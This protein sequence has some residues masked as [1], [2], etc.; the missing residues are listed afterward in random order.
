MHT[1]IRIELPIPFP[2]G[3]VNAILLPGDE[4]TLVDTGLKT[5]DCRQALEKG[6]A[7]NGMKVE[8]LRK[9]VLTHAHVDHAGLAA[10][11]AERSGAEVWVSDVAYDWIANLTTVWPQRG[12]L[13]NQVSR[14]G[15]LPQ[16][17][18]D[19]S[20]M[21]M[22]ATLAMWDEVPEEKLRRFPI[23]GTLEMGGG[24]WQVIYAPGH[25][26][27]Q[28]CFY[29][30]EHKWLIS[31]DMILHKAPTPVI[32]PD[33]DGQRVK[34]LPI[35]IEMVKQFAE[36]DV[37]ITF[38]GHG[39]LIHDHRAVLKQQIDR[40]EMRKNE[41]LDL[42][43]AGNQTVFAITEVMY[44][45]YPPAARSSGFGMVIGYLDLLTSEGLVVEQTVDGVWQF[46]PA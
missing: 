16:E 44:A 31:A 43:K 32:D 33:P 11:L 41:V 21:F 39:P 14:L 35:F 42:V 3:P 27:S 17:V 38:P 13:M 1:P 15:G 10:E 28:T 6:L 36:L 45:H 20:K 29:Q 2:V 34:G 37:E 23:D 46:S 7:D 40:I 19:R 18:R 5:A 12:E 25:T 22:E 30:P 9:I 26:V 8:D 4:P 24:R